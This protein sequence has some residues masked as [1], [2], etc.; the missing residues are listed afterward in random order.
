MVHFSNIIRNHNEMRE[1][2]IKIEAMKKKIKAQQLEQNPP[3]EFALRNN[4]SALGQ[5]EGF[6]GSQIV[7]DVIAD[8][9]SIS[10]EML[11]KTLFRGIESSFLTPR[12]AKDLWERMRGS[13]A[14]NTPTLIRALTNLSRTLQRLS[15]KST[16][17]STDIQQIKVSIE[18]ILKE[19]FPDVNQ[20]PN[21]YDNRQYTNI[22]NDNRVVNVGNNAG[23]PPGGN[24]PPPPGGL[25]A[26]PPLGLA[27]PPGAPPAPVLRL[28]APPPAPVI[29]PVPSAP[30]P[31][32]V[33]VPGAP[34]PGAPAPGAPAA[35]N[36]PV[37]PVPD[38]IEKAIRAM[39]AMLAEEYDTADEAFVPDSQAEA[40]EA[41]DNSEIIKETKITPQ[42]AN[43]ALT[44]ILVK[45]IPTTIPTRQMGKI[46][47]LLDRNMN[48]KKSAKM[49]A[50]MIQRYR[51]WATILY[52]GGVIH[53]QNFQ[54]RIVDNQ[55]KMQSMVE[56]IE[57]LQDKELKTNKPL[58]QNPNLPWMTKFMTDESDKF[59]TF[60]ANVY[61]Q[62]LPAFNVSSPAASQTPPQTPN[63]PSTGAAS[64]ADTKVATP[65]Q[66]GSDNQNEI[67]T[68]VQKNL[69]Q[70][71][72]EGLKPQQWGLKLIQRF[73]LPPKAGTPA[74]L[75]AAAKAAGGP[76]PRGKSVPN[77]AEKAA[78]Q[79][80][81][82]S[83][84]QP[85]T[86]YASKLIADFGLPPRTK[87]PA[88]PSPAA[89]SGKGLKHTGLKTVKQIISRTENLI[90]AANLGNK[91][92]EVR[93][94]LDTLLSV[95][96]DRKEVRPQF[97]TNLMK[98]LF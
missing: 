14:N 55:I 3:E 93:N 67:P 38:D 81:A 70:V 16:F 84:V 47:T 22:Y 91:S 33:P 13:V 24:N 66:A 41:E 12:N 53:G 36:I 28:G 63:Q 60:R 72:A 54:E 92:T 52:L 6:E 20:G 34:A 31:A 17:S 76:I 42:Q 45:Q 25:G 43:E 69:L 44:R 30:V 73:G 2:I 80:Y 37:Q 56:R 89:A 51:A 50:D 79:K 65:V 87:S 95:L 86:N 90:Q 62:S 39:D 57:K 10:V 97:R 82:D 83:D 32:P 48:L 15:S 46:Q 1:T 9:G 85:S 49:P 61:S 77:K 35:N 26:P 18:Q 75:A 27:A 21:M 8:T 23:R 4:T 64:G 59:K 40:A 58:F 5:S 71:Y 7:D 68:Q 29:V 11:L 78:L 19:L 98:K 94:E 88:T 74:A 96:I